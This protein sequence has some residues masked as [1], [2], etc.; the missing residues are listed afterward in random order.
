M[1]SIVRKF[2]IHYNGRIFAGDAFGGLM[3]ALIAL[4]YGLSMA[5]LMGLPPVLGLFTSIATAPIIT[6]LGRNS[7]MIGGTASPTLPFIVDAV[8]RQ[9]VGG[10]AKISIVAAI[11]LMVFSVLRL[12][13]LIA[14]VPQTVVSGFSCGIGAMMIIL[15]LNTMFGLQLKG[16]GAP[17]S[18]FFTTLSHLGLTRWEPALLSLVVVAICQVL[19]IRWKRFPGPLVAVGVAMALAAFMNMHE[20]EV[21]SLPL[22]IPPLAGFSWSPKEV[23]E[24]LVQGFGLAFVVAVYV[25]LTARVVEHFR[26]R[27]QHTKASDADAELGAYGIANIVAG[28]FGAPVSVGIP[29]RSVANVRCGGTTR[30]S[31]LIHAII[32][33]LLLWLGGNIVSHIPMAALA[34]VTAWMGFCLLDWSAWR[35][36][37]KMRRVDAGAFLT[38]AIAVLI[39]NAVLAVAL[40]CAWY[41]VRLLWLRY[42]GIDAAQPHGLPVESR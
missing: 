39:T 26:G 6:L 12:G 9:G 14:K 20:K 17:L 40:G 7:V 23:G 5:T 33:V 24:I 37:P 4:P 13:R 3:A 1:T 11:F 15:Q 21:G 32:L 36:L 22:E 2:R 41:G 18:Q 19:S 30:M 16:G 35:R 31:N 28:I 8:Q 34:G 42:K 29:A 38:T 25:L 27:H 10:A